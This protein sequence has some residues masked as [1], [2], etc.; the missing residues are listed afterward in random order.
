MLDN[1]TL[2]KIAKMYYLDGMT[3]KQIGESICISR[4]GIS[5]ALKRCIDEGIVE[6]KIKE[7]TPLNDLEES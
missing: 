2:S 3:Q 5:R 7:F 1:N 6:I 4:I